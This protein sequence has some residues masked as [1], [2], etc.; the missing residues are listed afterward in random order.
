M[1]SAASEDVSLMVT[2]LIEVAAMHSGWRF[3]PIVA[4]LLVAGV[5]ILFLRPTTNTHSGVEGKE[6]EALRDILGK[7]KVAWNADKVDGLYEL[8]HPQSELRLQCDKFDAAK[9]RFMAEL[10]SLIAELGSIRSFGIGKYIEKSH[11][12]VVKVEYEKRGSMPGTVA[13]RETEANTYMILDFDIDGE[14]EPEL[15]Q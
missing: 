6:Q 14:G 15:S 1:G 13:L 2:H 8:H 3:V 5:S 10:H 12:Y 4:L 9:K 11:R 7:W